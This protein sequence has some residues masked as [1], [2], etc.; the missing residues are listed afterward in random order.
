MI[1]KDNIFSDTRES[2]RNDD[3]TIEYTVADIS[4]IILF[5]LDNNEDLIEIFQKRLTS[6][7]YYCFSVEAFE[8]LLDSKKL[9][10]INM[11]FYLI[12]KHA[13][14]FPKTCNSFFTPYLD[15]LLNFISNYPK[16]EQD[17]SSKWMSTVSELIKLQPMDTDVDIA[18][19]LFEKFDILQTE[20]E[21]ASVYM[22]YS[23]LL[24]IMAHYE[25]DVNV[26]FEELIN[27]TGFLYEK[28]FAKSAELIAVQATKF[29]KDEDIY[30]IEHYIIMVNEIVNKDF[31]SSTTKSISKSLFLLLEFLFSKLKTNSGALI[32][33]LEIITKDKIN[34]MEMKS[35]KRKKY[36]IVFFLHTVLNMIPN[37]DNESSSY[38]WVL[39]TIFMLLGYTI[40]IE[41]ILALESLKYLVTKSIA[42]GVF[43]KYDITDIIDDIDYAIEDDKSLIKAQY[44]D[45]IKF[46]I[47]N[48]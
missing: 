33:L 37:A 36:L 25:Q 15:V 39:D 30:N 23:I 34:E 21:N 16:I 44:F 8:A 35:A 46:Q 12:M 7:N 41:P 18:R 4:E 27:K 38:I 13:K 5:A 40:E 14:Y 6:F 32:K 20:E 28:G 29:Y 26:K 31:F 42:L 2:E 11:A 45:D 9:Y 48:A 47:E 1:K 22:G 43:E 3:I 17:I 19:S 24:C 10:F